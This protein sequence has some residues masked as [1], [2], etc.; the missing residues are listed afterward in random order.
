MQKKAKKLMEENIKL[1]CKPEDWK[2]L[3]RLFSDLSQYNNNICVS[4][5]KIEIY[6]DY[7]TLVTDIHTTVTI[8]YNE[9]ENELII[10]C[11]CYEGAAPPTLANKPSSKDEEDLPFG[12]Q[13]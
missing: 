12:P 2:L 10:T 13:L 1:K 4:D 5:K 3:K 8:Y 11:S 7:G 6:S 9:Y